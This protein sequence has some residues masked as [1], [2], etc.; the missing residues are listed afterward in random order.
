MSSPNPAP[1]GGN[2]PGRLDVA[3]FVAVLAV[4]LV[5]ILAAHIS[6]EALTLDL[7]ALAGLYFAW[8]TRW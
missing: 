4:G 2:E 6:P 1:R 5:L 3:T 7:G 8:R